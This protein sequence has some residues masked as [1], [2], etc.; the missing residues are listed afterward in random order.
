MS[1]IMTV[2]IPDMKKPA[3]EPHN[4]EY[5]RA[6]FAILI[7]PMFFVTYGGTRSTSRIPTINFDAPNKPCRHCSSLSSQTSAKYSLLGELVPCNN[8]ADWN[9]CRG[10]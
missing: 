8:E 7:V 10:E 4:A 1:E 9:D 5:G 6:R 2:T 3:E